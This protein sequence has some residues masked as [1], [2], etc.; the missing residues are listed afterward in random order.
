[1][2]TRLHS[3]TKTRKHSSHRGWLAAMFIALL[4]ACGVLTS[5]PAFAGTASHAHGY[6]WSG[7]GASFIGSYSVNGYLAYCDKVAAL[8]GTHFGY[9][10]PNWAPSTG[11]SAA[12]KAKLAYLMREYGTSTNNTTAA[13]V[14]LNIWRLTGMNGHTDSYYAARANGS[15]AAVLAAA[16]AERTAMNGGATTAVRASATVSIAAGTTTGTVS[17][18][19]QVDKLAGWSSLATGKY[20]GTIKLTGAVFAD[21]GSVTRAVSNGTSYPIKATVTAGKFSA[22]ATVT[23]SKL[24]FGDTVGVMSSTTAGRQPLIVAGERDA[25]AS[26][27]AEAPVTGSV[28]I[29]FELS[30]NTTAS[31]QTAKPG[32]SLTDTLEVAVATTAGNPDAL[33]QTDGETPTPAPI[34]VTIR[35][36]LW[37][38]FDTAPAEADAPPSDA[39]PVCEVARTVTAKGTYE[40]GS[41]LVTAP[42]Y[43]VWTASVDPNDSPAATRDQVTA[44]QS[45]YGE[46]AETTVVAWQ[47][48]ATTRASAAVALSGTCVSDTI[49]ISQTQPGGALAVISQLWG[50]FDSEPAVGST[51]DPHTAPLV[52]SRSTTTNGDGE[53]TTGCI[54]VSRPGYYVW[55]YQSA[56]TATTPA[57]GSNQVFEGETTLVKW[58][59]TA[60]TVVSQD[61]ATA[62]SCVSDKITLTGLQPGTAVD[63]VSE[64]WGPF[65]AR[66]A[67]GSTIDST[68]ARLESSSTVRVATAG[69]V[70]TPCRPLKKVG[71]Y[72][73][74]YRSAGAGAMAPFSSSKVFANETVKVQAAPSGLAFTGTTLGTGELTTIALVLAGGGALLATARWR[75]RR[76]AR[77]PKRRGL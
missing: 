65:T 29:P 62:G 67:P 70:T 45:K 13:A 37:G 43:Y 17:S 38:P 69:V 15:K 28:G 1:M 64:V 75:R 36:R 44:V 14:G 73:Y 57:F 39:H 66:P 42:G 10:G 31:I 4:T 19:L 27:S 23:F 9:N 51:I 55:T 47:P 21:T 3:P 49:R 40:S 59:P 12:T 58:Q 63:V 5:G 35:S 2:T 20:A 71:Y 22:N 24:P 68:V 6:T 11:W 56:A 26:G 53:F 72:I 60:T 46:K 34:P 48:D 18:T 25:T 7:D 74:T 16:N 50:P 54:T 52:G 32:A 61:T 33:W 77:S 41:C 8:P 76:T 30:I